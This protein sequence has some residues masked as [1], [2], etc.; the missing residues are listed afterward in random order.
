M[1][2]KKPEPVKISLLDLPAKW[3]MLDF[4]VKKE[5]KK[6]SDEMAVSLQAGEI[7]GVLYDAF[8]KQYKDPGKG[9]TLKSLNKLCVRIVFLLYG[10]DA[11]ILGRKGMFHDYM[12]QFSPRHARDGLRK[13]FKVLN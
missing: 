12:E 2:Q 7:V 3:H 4:L 13:L 10:E 9:E 6:V 11:G 1:E 8:L 5:V